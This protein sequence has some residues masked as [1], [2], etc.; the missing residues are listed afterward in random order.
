MTTTFAHHVPHAVR[1]S[2]R[3]GLIAVIAALG[4]FEIHSVVA[5]LPASPTA[6]T[7]DAL[8]AAD[9]LVRAAHERM[10]GAEWKAL[11]SF[12]TLATAK[13]AMGDATIEFRFVAPDSRLL[14][15]TMPGGRGAMELGVTAGVAWM[16]EPGKARAVDPRMAEELAGGGDLQTLVHS[17]GERFED[18]R[19][20]SR[21]TTDNRIVWRISM[22]PRGTPTPDARW[23]LL[24]D[25][26][27]GL[28]HGFDIPAP[29]KDARADAPT[30]TGQSI[31]LSEWRPVDV[32]DSAPRS[33]LIAFRTAKVSAGGMET[34][35]QYSKVAINTLTAEAIRPPEKLEPAAPMPIPTN[36]PKSTPKSTPDDGT[37]KGPSAN[38]AAAP[39]N[40]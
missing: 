39:R 23:T 24:L 6:W 9:A 19:T 17:I 33:R 11:K 29:P 12:H 40:N 22:R 38:P 30:P 27:T 21:E 5:C 15:Q 26:A 4:A 7:Q 36:P 35:L 13:S 31:R 28:V 20:E 34:E 25:A 1:T 3:I 14:V 32:G 18:F 37:T 16:G 2:K 8:P 10:G